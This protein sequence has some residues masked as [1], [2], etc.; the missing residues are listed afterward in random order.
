MTVADRDVLGDRTPVLVQ[1]V[2][3]NNGA[4]LRDRDI[5]FSGDLAIV[6]ADQH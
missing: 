5:H 6:V 1:R 4:I 3:P 2:R